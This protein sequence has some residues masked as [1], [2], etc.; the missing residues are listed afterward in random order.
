MIYEN[1]AICRAC[2]Y[3]KFYILDC[4]CARCD[5]CDIHAAWCEWCA[6]ERR[7]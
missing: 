6:A 7:G 1:R 3:A 5:R 4:G 2:C